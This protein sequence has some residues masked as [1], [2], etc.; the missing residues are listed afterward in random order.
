MN[1]WSA[2]CQ[3][4]KKSSDFDEFMK[5]VD[6]QKKLYGNNFTYTLIDTRAIKKKKY[7]IGLYLSI[8]GVGV[9]SSI[10]VIWK[11]AQKKII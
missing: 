9:I 10:L 7:R 4:F 8:L 3:V 6:K 11:L 5:L 2:G 1:N